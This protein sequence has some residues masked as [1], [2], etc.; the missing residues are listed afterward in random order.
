MAS[1]QTSQEAAFPATRR[2]RKSTTGFSP[3]NATDKENTSMEEFSAPGGLASTAAASKKKL[4]SKSMGPGGLD[5]LKSTSGNRRVS[6]AVPSRPP[7]RSILKPTMPILPDIPPLKP[8]TKAKGKG[9][10]A[11]NGGDDNG[12]TRVALR[13]EEEQQAAARE[14]EERERAAREKEVK[15]HREAR[16]K[17]LANRRV[18][19]AAEATLHTFHEMDYPQDSTTST[20]RPAP[21][22]APPGLPETQFDRD[23]DRELQGPSDPPSTP[24][25]QV[26]DAEV[27]ESPPDNQREMHQAKNRRSSTGAP[28]L[29]F[30]GAMA[31]GD[32]N[33]ITSTVYDSDGGDEVEEDEDGD[34]M[35]DDDVASHS[36]SEAGDSDEGDGATMVTVDA[37]E[38]TSA[39]VMSILSSIS[40]QESMSPIE[41]TTDVDEA[42]RLA[43]EH[44]GAQADET[45]R[46][47]PLDEDE[48]VIQGFIGW[49]SKKAANNA[50]PSAAAPIQHA[51]QSPQ[52]ERDEDTAMSMD[53][54]M[55]MDMDMTRPMG[56]IIK[57]AQG[58][59]QEDEM[60]MDVTRAYGG[61]IL[62]QP[63]ADVESV[64]SSP[65]IMP[66]D[67]LAGKEP[68]EL[69]TGIGAIRPA[70]DN[71]AESVDQDGL[72]DMSMEL[73]A[74]LGG[75][76]GRPSFGANKT[77]RL[78]RRQTIRGPNDDDD[79]APM[80]ITLGVGKI[81]AG[82][83]GAAAQEQKEN[84]DK[85]EDSDDDEA[86]MDEATMTMGM[87][88]TT[89]LGGI[90]KP[91]SP[92][93]RRSL[94]P[95]LLP[96]PVNGAENAENTQTPTRPRRKS[97]SPPKSVTRSATKANATAS[98]GL[99]AF[100]GKGIHR[101]PARGSEAEGQ[102]SARPVSSSPKK[103]PEPEPAT[104]PSKTAAEP[105][106][107][108][109]SSPVRFIGSRSKSPK[110][111]AAS[112]EKSTTPKSLPKASTASFS[113]SLFS[114][115]PSTGAT[116]PPVVLT[117]QGRRR[118]TA[119][120]GA[121]P[122]SPKI[123]EIFSRRSSLVDAASE[124]VVGSAQKD[125]PA[126]SFEELSR[127]GT[128]PDDEATGSGPLDD[129]EATQ[130]LKDLIQ[131]LSPKKNPLKGRKS[132][133]VGSAKGLLGKRPHELDED[134]L[135]DDDLESQNFVKRLKGE[136][137]PVKN[138]RLQQPPSMMETIGRSS[139]SRRSP[140]A[141]PLPFDGQQQ[142]TTPSKYEN[143][144]KDLN[145]DDDNDAAGGEAAAEDEDED[146]A[147]RIHLQDFLKLANIHFMELE[148]TKRRATEGPGA[149]NK[150]SGNSHSRLS[151]DEDGKPKDPE[152]ES[153]VTTVCKVPL[154]EMYQHACREL[155]NY[156]EEGRSIMREIETETYEDNPP[157]FREYTTATPEMRAQMDNQFKNIK[158]FARLQSKKQWYE[159]RTKLHEGLQEGMLK[160]LR[161]LQKDK[162]VLKERR[163]KVDAVYPAL[164]AEYEALE[165]ERV[166]LETFA[167]QLGGDNQ[168][169][170]IA[171]RVQKSRLA[172][173]IEEHKGATARLETEMKESRARVAAMKTEREQYLK[174]L[175]EAKRIQEERRSWSHQ[176]ISSLKTQVDA[177]EKK[178]G[179]AVTG[180]QGTTLSMAYRREIELV[181]DVAAFRP[182]VQSNAQIDLWYIGH[183]RTRDPQPCTPE[184]EFF[185]QCIRDHVRGLKQA[186]T[187]P[188][189]LLKVVRASWDTAKQA[190]NQIRHLNLTFP[191][192]TTKTSDTSIAV[193]VSI[194]LAPLRT[195]VEVT[196][197]LRSLG[198]GSGSGVNSSSGE[199]K[200]RGLRIAVSSEA[201][202]VYGEP[203]NAAKMGEFL[204][205]RIGKRV[206]SGAA[207]TAAAKMNKGKPAAGYFWV[208]MMEELKAKLL[209][210]GRKLVARD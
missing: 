32:D 8:K 164:L 81:F 93:R 187:H 175:E 17:S 182:G 64:A 197:H 27:V 78:S 89:A 160:V 183:T 20:D 135:D 57:P 39:S 30:Q 94:A 163:D 11:R 34:E 31:G 102:Q 115:N 176:E 49:G 101:T 18:S 142:S 186:E 128:P 16:R 189:R 10:P 73:T 200:V 134:D 106:T 75:V 63:T 162:D 149:L 96:A 44:A 118:Q 12:T 54:D 3:S 171:A 157:I 156:I 46:Q 152:I 201:R 110:R 208:D 198:S 60:S 148:T 169:A 1:S 129:R 126:V 83:N 109:R 105:A 146:D 26:E 58:G 2:T 185:L 69:T 137:S 168:E 117:P 68:M 45:R 181:F 165:R 50:A 76:L 72:E 43:T 23:L 140:S 144:S 48:E 177:L 56:G 15:D 191:T 113:K 190:A 130:N 139:R 136:P 184:T 86:N 13:T 141:T 153:L 192:T 166:Q 131:N 95:A 147:E 35:E 122:S 133:H 114:Q 22:P 51:V 28:A 207:A 199:K 97:S 125:R 202:V 74:V 85:H 79:D 194:L 170:L 150:D 66:D 67:N 195:K 145:F 124:F 178:S 21:S 107:P 120:A 84:E 36:D 82:G 108:Q 7:P 172:E 161:D 205:A 155:K 119:Y 29:G 179:W 77:R 53:M 24:P 132:L 204:A 9:S 111:K 87:E 206:A 98:P 104:K 112:A 55:D 33:T 173:T 37:D 100:S 151:T 103:A 6:L 143:A 167:A 91:V 25:E 180:A 41:S 158:I 99:S 62:P 42:L 174:E 116:G 4:R 159:W 209:V 38:M 19:F 40:M 70:Q 88:I 196:L 61:I 203:F 5:A 80:D 92:A 121:G 59:R 65:M 127:Q 90:L 154:L 210:R 52:S 138:V 188:G 14:R 193:A 123:T 71:D 47:R